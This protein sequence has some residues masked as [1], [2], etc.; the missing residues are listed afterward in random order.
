M[1]EDKEFKVF[2]NQLEILRFISAVHSRVKDEITSDFTLGFLTEKEKE[3]LIE[4]TTNAYYMQGIYEYM[5]HRLIQQHKKYTPETHEKMIQLITKIQGNVFKT[6]MIKNYL[7]A[8]LSRNNNKNPLLNILGHSNQQEE[9]NEE[10]KQATKLTDRIVAK[11]K[12]Q[13]T[14]E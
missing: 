6:F 14:K 7:I 10:E 4:M 11:L 9:D 2:D 5:K 3:F 1:T 12:P 13:T 8:I